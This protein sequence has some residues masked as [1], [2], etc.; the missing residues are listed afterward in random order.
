MPRS[1]GHT[2]LWNDVAVNAL[3]ST[4]KVNIREYDSYDIYGNLTSSGGV[5]VT[6]SIK[7]SS[8]ASAYFTTG[9]E[10]YIASGTGDFY[11]RFENDNEFLKI[12]TDVSLSNAYLIISA[13]KIV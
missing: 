8:D 3:Q 11:G 9:Q 7:T 6:L 4:E 2:L 5:P 12:S 10:V 1:I 13:K